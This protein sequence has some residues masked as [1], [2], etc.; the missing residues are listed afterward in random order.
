[1]KKEFNKDIEI[2]NKNQVEVLEK[3]TK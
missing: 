1:M 3:K 2:L